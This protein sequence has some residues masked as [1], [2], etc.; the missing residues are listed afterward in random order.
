MQEEEFTQFLA[1]LSGVQFDGIPYTIP[2]KMKGHVW[3]KP[4]AA[5]VDGRF[6]LIND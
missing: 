5:K 2:V 1:S 3:N 6:F 4:V